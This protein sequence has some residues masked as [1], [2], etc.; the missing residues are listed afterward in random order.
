MRNLCI[1]NKRGGIGLAGQ[2]KFI[3]VAPTCLYIQNKSPGTKL[4][5]LIL[6]TQKHAGRPCRNLKKK[7]GF[8][9]IKEIVCIINL[10]GR[11]DSKYV[12]FNL[13]VVINPVA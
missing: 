12:W 7:V 1:L 5:S 8:F 13:V 10:G 2:P 6:P 4:S 11:E 3:I 9:I